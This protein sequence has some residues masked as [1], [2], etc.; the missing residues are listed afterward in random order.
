MDVNILQLICFLKINLDPNSTT[1]LTQFIINADR[2]I[3]LSAG[4]TNG[5][6]NNGDGGTNAGT[7]NH[8]ENEDDDGL[9]PVTA[10]QLAA[11]CRARKTR[12]LIL[13]AMQVAAFLGWDLDTLARYFMKLL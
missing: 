7:T 9:Q 6:G 11:T 3:H 4:G 13:M 12:S 10:E 2:A 8:V 1:L 5:N